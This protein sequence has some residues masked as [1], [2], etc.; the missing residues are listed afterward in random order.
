MMYKVS[1]RYCDH[2]QNTAA[3]EFDGGDCLYTFL[4]DGD[5]HE[6]YEHWFADG[7]CDFSNNFKKCDFDGGDC[8]EF[9]ESGCVQE[10]IGDSY[11]DPQLNTELCDFDGGDCGSL[12]FN[13]PSE[14]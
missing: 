13:V 12:S 4:I 11:C 9:N 3:C 2:G 7:Y 5:K 6:C 8:D 10:M 1:F 14:Y